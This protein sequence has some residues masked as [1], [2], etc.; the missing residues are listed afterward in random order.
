MPKT[1]STETSSSWVTI[2][3]DGTAQPNPGPAAAAAVLEWANG[4]ELTVTVGLGVATNNVAAYSGCIVGLKKALELG[5]DS[6]IITGNSELVIEQLQGHDVVTAVANL[7]PLYL[8]AQALLAQF[9]SY[10]C[11][12]VP[13]EQNNRADVAMK[14]FL[15][16]NYGWLA[17]L[18]ENLP[19][20]VPLKGL[21]AKISRLIRLG[22][23]AGFQDFLA[24][25][26][27]RDKFSQMHS[28]A[29]MAAVPAAISTVIASVLHN[30]EAE[31]F[32]AEV[33]RWW[34]RGLPLALAWRKARVDSE[35]GV[36][37][38]RRRT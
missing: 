1:K 7:L 3:F 5:V 18:P 12:W 13:P 16:I 22:N 38:M 15:A 10:K 32:V 21:K 20:A 8:E 6:V 23:R 24:L 26:S 2:Y 31:E 35:V 29:L 28:S 27:E 25:N 14:Q 4:E 11:K 17:V 34:L 37:A 30:S 36:N 19:V 33:Y 9:D